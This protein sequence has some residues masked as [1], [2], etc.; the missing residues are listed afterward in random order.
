MQNNTVELKVEVM[1]YFNDPLK[2]MWIP[3][4]NC[5]Y[6]G[7]F[8]SLEKEYDKDKAVKL[9]KNIY[10]KGHLSIFEM[11][12]FQ[13]KIS[14][15]SRSCLSQLTRSRIGWSYAVQS[16]HF[17][18]HDNFKYKNLEKYVDEKHKNEYYELMEQINIFY[19]KS[20]SSGIPKY[21][22]REVLPNSCSVHLVLKTNLR[23][24]DH[25]WKLR[26]GEDNTPEIRRLSKLLYDETEKV[27]PELDKIIE[28]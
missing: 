16:Q 4:R 1:N 19:K 12:P 14:G 7:D 28:Y 21:I 5:W 23:S 10:N 13:Y 6:R 2:A 8:D 24:L 11:A 20:I 17:Q 15:M 3:A 26:K 25:F 18:T 27:F 9:L 22:A